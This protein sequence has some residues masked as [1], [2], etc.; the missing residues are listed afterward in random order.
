MNEVY[1][2]LISHGIALYSANL[3]LLQFFLLLGVFLELQDRVVV[4]NI[5]DLQ[6][7]P[8]HVELA[9]LLVNGIK[10]KVLEVQA[11]QSFEEP[12]AFNHDRAGGARKG[13]IF[14]KE[15]IVG[16]GVL[17]A[18]A[19]NVLEDCKV[20]IFYILA[21]KVDPADQSLIRI[22]QKCLEFLQSLLFLGHFFL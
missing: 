3:K 2:H 1:Y 6:H 9:S 7:Q 16:L 12:T 10:V 14:G 22:G 13:A 18:H 19:D 4:V 20:V 21:L 11:A 8:L 5:E 15:I 17:N